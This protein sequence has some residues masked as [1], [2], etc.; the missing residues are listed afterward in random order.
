MDEKTIYSTARIDEDI[1]DLIDELIKDKRIL[2]RSRSEFIH[3]TLR[4]KIESYFTLFP[5][6]KSD[7]ETRLK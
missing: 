7:V 3:G 5:D 4:E 6:L 2:Y 1:L